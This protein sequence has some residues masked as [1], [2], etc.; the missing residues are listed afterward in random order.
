[1]MATYLNSEDGKALLV[2]M[3]TAVSALE[4]WQIPG[5]SCG[6]EFRS[7]RCVRDS[8][9]SV[10]CLLFAP[11]PNPHCHRVQANRQATPSLYIHAFTVIS[12]P[13]GVEYVL[14]SGL[15]RHLLWK[16]RCLK[17]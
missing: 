11:R 2:A 1:M 7:V 12:I 13:I 8:R 17:G 15:L 3:T 10:K 9:S 16:K 4:A 5:D 14:G 6:G